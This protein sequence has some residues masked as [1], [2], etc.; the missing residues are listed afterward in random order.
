[1]QWDA[2]KGMHAT[3]TSHRTVSALLPPS[4]CK[5]Q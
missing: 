1:M 4:D 2:S 5:M 3:P